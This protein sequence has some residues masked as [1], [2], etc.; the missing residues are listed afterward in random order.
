LQH[1]SAAQF[2]GISRAGTRDLDGGGMIFL[3]LP[4]LQIKPAAAGVQALT[5]NSLR[6][7]WTPVLAGSKP[8]TTMQAKE[9]P[10]F[11]PSR[12]TLCR[13]GTKY[14]SGQ[15]HVAEKPWRIIPDASAYIIFAIESS[16]GRERVRCSV[17]GTREVY[18]DIN[19]ARRT[20]ISS[21]NH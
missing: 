11:T 18:Y 2:A 13:I 5:M 15:H 9:N 3:R 12:Y 17:V 4:N 10:K 20:L 21:Y 14:R 7:A 6:L 19:V 1:G 16:A 8:S